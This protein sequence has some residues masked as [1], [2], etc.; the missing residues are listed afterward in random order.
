M[1]RAHD[2]TL[3]LFTSGWVG[4]HAGTVTRLAN[5]AYDTSEMRVIRVLSMKNNR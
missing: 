5:V 3:F 1:L 4:I 2:I